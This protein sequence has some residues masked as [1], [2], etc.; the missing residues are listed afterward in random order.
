MIPHNSHTAFLF[1]FDGTLADTNK[2]IIATFLATLQDLHLP[3]TTPAAIQATIG[4]PLEECFRIAAHVP[5]E[6]IALAASHYRDIFMDIALSS[7][8]LFPNVLETLQALHHQG[9]PMA[10]VSSRHPSSLLPLVAHLDLQPCFHCICG[11]DPSIRPKPAPDLALKA[12][13]ELSLIY[14]ITPSNAIVVGDTQYDILMGNQ[15]G[16]QTCAVVYGNQ[17]PDQLLTA[18]PTFILNNLGNIL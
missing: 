2:G 17:G 16:C 13:R 6:K 4:L 18:N 9:N 8:S 14:P 1:D 5:D 7:I 12:L 11:E 3:S 15:A 10:I